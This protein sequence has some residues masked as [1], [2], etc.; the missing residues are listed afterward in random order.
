MIQLTIQKRYWVDHL[1]KNY[2][3]GPTL[4]LVEKNRKTLEEIWAKVISA[5]CNV[6]I[7]KIKIKEDE[8]IGLAVANIINVMTERS[9]LAETHKLEQKLY[10][11]RWAR[12]NILVNRR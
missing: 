5:Y 9:L 6:T 1:K 7:W 2:L 4:T 12:K 3:T 8:K 10:V 11:G